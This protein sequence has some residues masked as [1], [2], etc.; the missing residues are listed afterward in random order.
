MPLPNALTI[1]GFDPSGAA[2][3]LADARTFASFGYRASAAITSITFQNDRSATG[4]AHQTAATV[5]GQLE[6]LRAEFQFGCA[7]TGMLPTREV[8][9]EVARIFRESELPAPVVDPVMVSSSGLRLMEADALDVFVAE[10][11]PVARAVTPNIPE[12]EALIGLHITSE[13]QMREA[14]KIIR[15]LGARAVLIKGGHLPAAPGAFPEE[16]IDVLDDD[17]KVTVFRAA[18][19]PGA[20]IRG[21]GCMLSAAIAAGLGKGLSLEDSVRQA[22]DFVLNELR[23]AKQS[24]HRER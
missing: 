4:A 23:N 17:G 7:K 18:F 12:A 1:A 22:K 16:A 9:R 19:I 2:G 24:Q 14:A 13:A 10:L 20:S 21:S 3:V 11:L 15:G 6:S 8:V 5:R